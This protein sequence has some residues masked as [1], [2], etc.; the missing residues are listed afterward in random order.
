VLA[1]K[2]KKEHTAGS[3]SV[4]RL[5]RHARLYKKNGPERTND[6]PA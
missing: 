1:P 4:L 5:P 6:Y 3:T 2:P